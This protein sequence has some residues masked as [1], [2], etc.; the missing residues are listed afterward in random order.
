[1]HQ[2]ATSHF[3]HS[4]PRGMPQRTP[5]VG[6]V[7]KLNLNLIPR[8]LQQKVTIGNLA[9]VFNFIQLPLQ[10]W[11]ITDLGQI[12][13]NRFLAQITKFIIKSLYS[14]KIILNLLG[15]N[16]IFSSNWRKIYS[17]IW[18]YRRTLDLESWT[19]H[20]HSNINSAYY[21]CDTSL[22]TTKASSPLF[23]TLNATFKLIIGIE[24]ESSYYLSYLV[25]DAG[26][27]AATY[28]IYYNKRKVFI[29]TNFA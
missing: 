7:F 12:R 27:C 8:R 21:F 28:L 14:V 26:L 18:H 29:L 2:H 9:Q 3:S 11:T 15:K 19:A 1:M 22:S 24:P 20:Y 10:R 6:F 16:F 13:L 5:S 23:L 25:I 17:W 4:I